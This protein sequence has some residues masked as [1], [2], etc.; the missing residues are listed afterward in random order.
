MFC[1][2]CGQKLPD[3]VTKCPMCGREIPVKK[4]GAAGGVP[5][6]GPVRPAAQPS[7]PVAPP[8]PPGAGTGQ[9]Y[10]PP[11]PGAGAAATAGSLDIGRSF[12][13][14][15]QDKSWIMKSLLLGLIVLIPILGL[16]VL[17]GYYIE[18][19]RRS[20][21]GQDLP[22]PEISFGAQ[23]GLGFSYFIPAIVA[24]LLAMAVCGM[25]FLIG[26]I[27]ILGIFLR[28]A[29]VLA[30]IVFYFYITGAISLS[31]VEENPWGIFQF[32]R[33]VPLIK[34][35]LLNIF[36]TMLVMIPMGIIGEAGIILLFVGLLVTL[37]MSV[38]M[39]GHIVGQL[40]RIMR[41]T[42]A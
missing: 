21:S 10:S 11:P 39:M 7:M 35:N 17:A 14:V 12:T 38:M 23:L 1:S 28:I 32:G 19:A 9:T 31:I 22:L 5:G 13:F 40:G 15:F 30:Y 24:G 20:A 42:E 18:T 4:E 16:F 29:G 41:E 8:P 27:P 37:P 34:T 6:S 33:I 2:R 26:Q 36:I 3:G 25:L